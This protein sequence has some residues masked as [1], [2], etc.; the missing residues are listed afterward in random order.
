LIAI[1]KDRLG[2]T[3]ALGCI[4]N[5]KN[6]QITRSLRTREKFGRLLGNFPASVFSRNL[7]YSF[8]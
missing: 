8:G 6:G 3:G 5:G 1:T 2:R 7:I 4:R